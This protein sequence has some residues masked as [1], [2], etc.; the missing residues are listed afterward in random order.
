MWSFWDNL[1]RYSVAKFN[2]LLFH[3]EPEQGNYQLCVKG[4]KLKFAL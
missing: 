4:F 1:A 3:S 2:G